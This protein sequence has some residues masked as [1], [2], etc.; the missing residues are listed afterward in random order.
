MNLKEFPL[1]KAE[2]EAFRYRIADVV[3]GI[4]H[5]QVMNAKNLDFKKKLLKSKDMKDYFQ[6]N[7]A[8]RESLVQ[9][10]QKLSKQIKEHAVRCEMEVPEYLVPDVI[11]QFRKKNEQMHQE[12]KRIL[13]Q[14]VN[15]NYEKSMKRRME[16]NNLGLEQV[17]KLKRMEGDK[18]VTVDEGRELNDEVD[19]SRLKITSG[20]KLWKLKRG[21]KLKKRNFRLEKKGIF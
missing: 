20:K 2:R 10:I 7:V 5:K 6:K 3:N 16:M 4:S 19:A 14:K 12:K 8:E 15:Q 17:K 18:Y 11:K 21:F 13:V 1:K 9:D